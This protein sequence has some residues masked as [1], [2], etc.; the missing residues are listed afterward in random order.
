[1]IKTNCVYSCIRQAEQRDLMGAYYRRLTGDD[2]KMRVAAAK[3]WSRW[4][5]ATSRLYVDDE[6]ISRA[7]NDQWSL[8]FARI[9]W[10]VECGHLCRHM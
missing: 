4:E 10:S 8:Q 3:Q 5:M 6:F 7:E 1:M 9:E 2:E